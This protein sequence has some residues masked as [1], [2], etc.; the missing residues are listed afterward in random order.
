MDETKVR[1][2]EYRIIRIKLVDGTIIHGQVN[3]NQE[4]GYDRVSDLLGSQA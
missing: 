3:I 1:I 2:M 4:E